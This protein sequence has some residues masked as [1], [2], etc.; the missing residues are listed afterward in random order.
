MHILEI[1][2]QA[3]AEP[4]KSISV[5]APR[6]TTVRI[7]TEKIREVIGPG[8]KMIRKITQESGAKIEID[9]E[10]LARV[11]SVNEEAS[12][13]AV[14]MIREITQEA[15][16]GQVYS[17]VVRRVT[18]FGVFCEFLPG[19]DGLVHI[20]ELSDSY[21]DDIDSV[22]KVG[23]KFNVKVLEVDV[24]G[25]VSLSRKQAPDNPA[26]VSTPRF[27]GVA[28]PSHAPGRHGRGEPPYRGRGGPPSGRGSYAGRG[29]PPHPGRG[30]PPHRSRSRGDY[31][32]RPP[33][34]D[35]FEHP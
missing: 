28:P 17:G 5:Y 20:S 4:R 19:K 29:G 10:G 3:I 9:D 13:K 15:E 23:D 34:R 18:S 31:P 8:G 27:S 12:K 30:G 21:V 33:R 22:V 35:R 6:I 14:E 7:P 26:L 24:Q 32:G 2:N 25:R 1:M 16:V 11:I